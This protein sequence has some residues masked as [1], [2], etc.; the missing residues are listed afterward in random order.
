MIQPVPE[1][2]VPNNGVKL[3][4]ESIM[5]S[6][7]TLIFHGSHFDVMLSCV[8]L[9]FFPANLTIISHTH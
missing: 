1:S 3:G 5:F 8:F 6:L 2:A 4:I 7:P 9:L